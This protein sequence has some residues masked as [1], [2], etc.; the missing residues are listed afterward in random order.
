MGLG[1]MGRSFRG[2]F[3]RKWGWPLVDSE[4]LEM[5]KAQQVPHG[6]EWRQRQEGLSASRSSDGFPATNEEARGRGGMTLGAWRA[7]FSQ[8]WPSEG[9]VS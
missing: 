8:S 5:E 3:T 1:F 4:A 9:R 7:W 6:E 2:L